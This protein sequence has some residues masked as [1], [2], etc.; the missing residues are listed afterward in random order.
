V[1]PRRPFA[2]ETVANS[3]ATKTDRV[4]RLLTRSATKVKIFY[5]ARS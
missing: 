4:N 2:T 3:L 5:L 1:I